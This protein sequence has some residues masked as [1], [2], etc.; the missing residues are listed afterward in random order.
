M[1][2]PYDR[3][4]VFPHTLNLGSPSMTPE[5]QEEF[6]EMIGMK[7][8]LGNEAFMPLSPPRAPQ[9]PFFDEDDEGA[10]WEDESET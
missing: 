4:V 6:E 2:N 5:E 10:D 3:R 9:A 1:P 8:C 7:L